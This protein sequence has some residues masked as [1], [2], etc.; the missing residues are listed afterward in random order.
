MRHSGAQCDSAPTS[1]WHYAAH[2]RCSPED[3]LICAFASTIPKSVHNIPKYQSQY[4]Q[5]K[6]E[7]GMAVSNKNKH[8]VG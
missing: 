3:Q 8:D 7:S 5:R 1:S 6:G 2:R 4:T